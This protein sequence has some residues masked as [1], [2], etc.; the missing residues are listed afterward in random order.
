M[1]D[2]FENKNNNLGTCLGK[3]IWNLFICVKFLCRNFSLDTTVEGLQLLCFG[4]L[5][6][7]AYRL[8]LVERRS[9]Q[10]S[11]ASFIH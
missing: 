8:C 3:K 10:G 9:H 11:A 7:Y 6:L 4:G 2:S 5:R 1:L